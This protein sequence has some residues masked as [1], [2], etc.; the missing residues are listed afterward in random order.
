MLLHLIHS[1]VVI[2]RWC[3]GL[4]HLTTESDIFEVK[5][6]EKKHATYTLLFDFQLLS[7]K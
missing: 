4:A 7:E 5:K 6:Q 1:L 2:S 3:F